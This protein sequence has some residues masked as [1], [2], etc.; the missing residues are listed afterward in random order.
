MSINSLIVYALLL[1]RDECE[2]IGRL[3]DVEGTESYCHRN[4]LRYPS[5]CPKDV[6]RCYSYDDADSGSNNISE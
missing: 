3:K 4:C 6:C 5:T 1:A 2:P